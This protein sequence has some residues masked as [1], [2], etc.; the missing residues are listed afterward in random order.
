[1]KKIKVLLFLALLASSIAASAHGHHPPTD[2]HDGGCVDVPLDGG[3]LSVL[4]AAG[5]GF[6]LLIKR[7]KDKVS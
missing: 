7:K 5:I 4:G 6:Y 3:L 2:W 1:M